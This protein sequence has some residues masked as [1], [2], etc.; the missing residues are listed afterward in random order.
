M[1]RALC[2]F[3]TNASGGVFHHAPGSVF[4]HDKRLTQKID[5]PGTSRSFAAGDGPFAAKT[6]RRL[7]RFH[8]HAAR[9]PRT[10]S[11]IARGLAKVVG[12]N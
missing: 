7:L 11:R 1:P 8:W 3:M 10:P 9:T 12:I 6:L 4:I 5:L 2:L